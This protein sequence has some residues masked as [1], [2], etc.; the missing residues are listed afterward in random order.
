MTSAHQ[1]AVQTVS[2]HIGVRG[3]QKGPGLTLVI[4][5][6]SLHFMVHQF[7]GKKYAVYSFYLE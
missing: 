3:L 2:S 5:N 1:D 4:G 6:E 7:V